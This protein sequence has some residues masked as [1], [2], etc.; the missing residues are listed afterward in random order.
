MTDPGKLSAWFEAHAAR[1]VLYAR[2]LAGERAPDVVQDAFV[3]LMQAPREPSNVKA[4]LYRAV[5]NAAV[6]SARTEQARA[7]RHERL[8]RQQPAWFQTSADDDNDP[9]DAAAAQ[10]CLAGLPAPLRE[11]VVLRIWAGMSF[12]EIAE[13]TGLPVSTVFD[14]YRRGLAAVRQAMEGSCHPTTKLN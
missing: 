12:A 9:L 5:R 11:V 14:H 6:S 8:G 7:R 13:T 3:R 4:W 10:S 2:Q 1:L